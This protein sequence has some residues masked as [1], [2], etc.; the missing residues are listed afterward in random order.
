MQETCCKSYPWML[1]NAYVSITLVHHT[2][3]RGAHVMYRRFMYNVED[4]PAVSNI[5]VHEQAPAVSEQLNTWEQVYDRVL[6]YRETSL[7]IQRLFK[8]ERT[9]IS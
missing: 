9:E 3:I 7:K 1:W 2:N 8:S 5:Q 4:H 6:G